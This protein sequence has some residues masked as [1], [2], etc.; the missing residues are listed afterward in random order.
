M[1]AL[2]VA[3]AQ[4]TTL[5]HCALSSDL[6]RLECVAEPIVPAV[7]APAPT[8]SVRGTSFPLDPA[9]RWVVDLWGPPSDAERVT[10]LA[11]AT[12]CYRSP[13]C[14]VQLTLPAVLASAR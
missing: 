7:S 13:G 2:L 3:V 12:I 6:V 4:V 1:D 5:W 11:Q 10:Q 9:R 8:A 14:A